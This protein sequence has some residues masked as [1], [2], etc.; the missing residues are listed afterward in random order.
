MVTICVGK[1]DKTKEFQGHRGLLCHYSSYFKGALEGGFKEAES[2]TVTLPE[3][4]VEVFEIFFSW[5]Y[6]RSL[7]KREHDNLSIPLSWSLLLQVHC[8]ADMRGV[9]RLQNMSSDAIID[10]VANEWRFPHNRFAYIYA[11]T[12]HKA[13]L[14]TLAVDMI[15]FTGILV[16][17]DCPLPCLTPDMLQDLVVAMQ[18]LNE[19]GTGWKWG[20]KTW[21]EINKCKYHVKSDGTPAFVPVKDGD[22]P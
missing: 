5:L 17:I 19:N 9:P 14:R 12:P 2:R 15:I 20:R 21:K 16:E 13:P 22:K 18:S 4:D 10:K 6:T 8:F 3:D 1:G 11:N 7:F